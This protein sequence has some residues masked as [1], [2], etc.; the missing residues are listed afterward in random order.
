ML[1]LA[2]RLSIRSVPPG[3]LGGR[4][5]GAIFPAFSASFQRTDFAG[6]LAG[7]QGLEPW[8]VDQVAAQFH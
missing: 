2:F 8:T 4:Q 7:A 5:S 6:Y 1:K 3:P